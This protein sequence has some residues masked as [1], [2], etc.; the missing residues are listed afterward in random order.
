VNI[1]I[2]GNDYSSYVNS[3]RNN[4]TIKNYVLTEQ[5]LEEA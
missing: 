1:A 5:D 4:G 2:A 3:G